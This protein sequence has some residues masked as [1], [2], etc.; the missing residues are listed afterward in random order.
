MITVICSKCEKKNDSGNEDPKKRC[1]AVEHPVLRR[2]NRCWIIPLALHQGIQNQTETFPC[3]EVE[4][5]NALSTITYTRNASIIEQNNCTLINNW[6]IKAQRID[7]LVF[8]SLL[9]PKLRFIWQNDENNTTLPNSR[10]SDHENIMSKRLKK[11]GGRDSRRQIA[12]WY[13]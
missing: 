13:Q 3:E 11:M 12:L 7:L 8:Y 4:L 5:W 1:E 10:V 2:Q 6:Q 9:L